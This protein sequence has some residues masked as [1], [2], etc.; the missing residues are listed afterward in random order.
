M[1]FSVLLLL[2]LL[3]VGCSDPKQEDKILKPHGTY[4]KTICLRGVEYY[5]D[6]VINTLVLAPALREDGKPYICEQ[7]GVQ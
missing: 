7:G 3:I 1:K 2:S 4:I 6:I 5:S